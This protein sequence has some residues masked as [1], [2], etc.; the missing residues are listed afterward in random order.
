MNC[1]GEVFSR[2]KAVFGD[3]RSWLGKVFLA[4]VK[5]P[6][7]MLLICGLIG[8]YSGFYFSLAG[9]MLGA[10]AGLSVG[11]VGICFLQKRKQRCLSVICGTIVFFVFLIGF[12]FENHRLCSLTDGQFYEG[13]AEIMSS[14]GKSEGYKNIVVKLDSGE[15]VT[16]LTDASYEVGGRMEL[17]G[18]LRKIRPS[19]NPGDMDIRMYYLKQGI[20]RLIDE[21]KVRN[22]QAPPWSA[23]S[24]L[25]L[26]QRTIRNRCYELWENS[27]GKEEAGLLSAMLLGDSPSLDKET[28]G[29]FRLSNLS[30]L[31]VVSGAHVGY[32]TASVAMLLALFSLDRK[33][34]TW[35][36]CI[37]VVIFGY[38]TG[39]GP[40]ATRSIL[41]YIS[42]SFLSWEDRQSDRL[43][44]CALSGLILMFT[45]PYS[46]FSSGLL[47][48]FGATFSILLFFK[49]MERKMRIILPK[50]PVEITRAVSCYLCALMGMFPVLITI[51]NR[52]TLMN[53]FTVVLAGFPAELL[54]SL[55]IPAT[56]VC[57]LV[58]YKIFH[59][60]LMFP[61]RGL[62]SLLLSMAKIGSRSGFLTFSMQNA[63][64]W[65]LMILIGSML[66][67]VIRSGIWKRTVSLGVATTCAVEGLLWFFPLSPAVRVYFLDV[68]QGDAALIC[69]QSGNYLIDGGNV[70]SGEKILSVMDSLDISRI[71]GAFASHL[72]S[73]HIGGLIELWNDEKITHLY[74][75]FWGESSEMEQLRMVY[76]VLPSDVDIIQA[77]TRVDLEG[78]LTFHVL[79]PESPKDGGNEDSM[80]IL[81]DIYGTTIL[82]TGDIGSESE[83]HIL[84]KLPK[85]VQVLK[86][87]HHGSRFST[88]DDFLNAKK[89]DA[90][91]ISVGYNF[92]GHPSKDV[93]ERLKIRD[94]PCFRTDDSGCV[95][96][97]IRPHDWNLRYYF[98]GE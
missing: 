66:L 68:G 49:R 50:I 83:S 27:M 84:E 6:F 30:H 8:G 25:R 64:L 58:P 85:Q 15:K 31:L 17:T 32:F 1:N 62:V 46:V 41:T 91:V 56:I 36:L 90:A 37:S 98:D 54:C 63:S 10:F 16:L 74:A 12:S 4:L 21:C 40:S 48:S 39:F 79:W 11:I 69:S 80:V 9:Q 5:R 34:K 14:Q 20:V 76:E 59:K 55:G 94:I 77:G 67:V 24:V 71:D 95:F 42:V 97:E 3:V 28:K 93:I 87:A 19:G 23:G 52:I 33:K 29:S 89:Y 70:G 86:V 45:D 73:D 75:P 72:D 7:V 26:L 78:S 92:Y 35:I 22:Y 53:L 65:C 38:I 44:A 47:L 43:S 57:I 18:T 2:A 61:F 81:A 13:M 60:F 96:L 88:S 51:G 82:F